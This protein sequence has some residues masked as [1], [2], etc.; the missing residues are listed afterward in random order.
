MEMCTSL[1]KTLSNP[2]LAKL[3]TT[4]ITSKL[5]EIIR[6]INTDL[7][8]GP[9]DFNV[10]FENPNNIT[11]EN[12][13]NISYRYLFNAMRYISRQGGNL[14]GT[15][16]N[17]ELVKS[18]NVENPTVIQL[19]NL[20]ELSTQFNSQTLIITRNPLD[21]L[22]RYITEELITEYVDGFKDIN[23]FEPE[24][25]K[26]HPV[27]QIIKFILETR[28]K[29]LNYVGTADT[30]L[31]FR[32]YNFPK[33][34]QYC[35]QLGINVKLLMGLLLG[36]GIYDVQALSSLPRDNYTTPYYIN[37][38]KDLAENG[39]L[40][41][42]ISG[43]D[44]IYGTNFIF[45]NIIMDN[46]VFSEPN[47][48]SVNTLFQ[49]ISRAGRVGKSWRAIVYVQDDVVTKLNEYIYQNSEQSDDVNFS[50]LCQRAIGEYTSFKDKIQQKVN[51]EALTVSKLDAISLEKTRRKQEEERRKQEEEELKQREIQRQ[52]EV[53]ARLRQEQE[54]LN[55]LITIENV[56][57]IRKFSIPEPVT[58]Y[59]S[60]IITD[61]L[62]GS[63]ISIAFKELAEKSIDDPEE[64]SRRNQEFNGI[65][66][67]EIP[68][69]GRKSPTRAKNDIITLNYRLLLHYLFKKWLL[70][71]DNKPNDKVTP[72]NTDEVKKLYNK[73]NYSLKARENGFG[74]RRVD[75]LEYTDTEQGIARLRAIEEDER[76]AKIIRFKLPSKTPDLE[77]MR[78]WINDLPREIRELKKRIQD[79]EISGDTELLECIYRNIYRYI[80]KKY[81]GGSFVDIE[82]GEVLEEFEKIIE[83]CQKQVSATAST[84]N[85]GNT[86]NS[87]GGSKYLVNKKY[88][89]YIIKN[90]N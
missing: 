19:N 72:E 8:S 80:V 2:F 39:K 70:N 71:Q 52:R 29:D 61:G 1:A 4:V 50:R 64:F 33:E 86:T 75:L 41:F 42:L 87:V 18:I 22:D 90:D 44:I 16:N 76:L 77:N 65:N 57:N 82:L 5:Y 37:L 6:G 59:F 73:I 13:Q 14:S 28:R 55:G 58:R 48:H 21:I 51:R 38:V 15:P 9:I 69:L 10:V 31:S 40:I 45:E 56:Y 78:T 49:A 46:T 47:P 43:S 27:L 17:F 60:P 62:A 83:G 54:E 7:V 85:A 36:I 88:N 79:I 63:A 30:P 84:T 11:Q 35:Q 34:N 3:Y 25:G 26:G 12:S 20:R 53:Q 67:D 23:R 24:Q 32:N 89:K 68:I 66:L 81:I 74:P